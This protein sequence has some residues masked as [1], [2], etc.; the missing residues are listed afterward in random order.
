MTTNNSTDDILLIKNV[1]NG[2]K[3][4]FRQLIDKYKYS[5]LKLAYHMM[6]NRQDAEDIA[7]DAFLLAYERL[8]QFKI[9]SNFHTWIY[10]IGNNL[11]KD[12]LR[13]RKILHFISLD[14]PVVTEDD[15]ITIEIQDT[16]RS[17]EETLIEKEE[18]KKISRLINS[19]PLKY[20]NI[21][22]LKHV[23]NMSYEEIS[24]ITGLN[25]KTVEVQLYRAHKMLVKN[26]HS[27]S[28]KKRL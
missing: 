25:K 22:L 4:D 5:I 2:S 28:M 27:I 18:N 23:E 21:F 24:K 10:T 9:D 20:R 1:L 7:Q 16:S 17:P 8:R 11:C 15:E 19:L 26:A 3:E 6:G 13:R 14:K 12:K